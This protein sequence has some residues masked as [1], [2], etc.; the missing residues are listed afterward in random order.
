MVA[1]RYSFDGKEKLL[2]LGVYPDVSLKDAR[3]RR[4]AARKLLANDTD[5]GAARK[6]QKQAKTERAANSFEAVAREW[7][8]KRLSGWAASHSSKINGAA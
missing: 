1:L 5:P 2:S 3:E 4:D 6:A 7:Y 8:A